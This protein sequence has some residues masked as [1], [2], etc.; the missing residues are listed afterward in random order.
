MLT[1][2][3]NYGVLHS[4][5]Q[6]WL[7][8]SSPL[9]I[10]ALCE[11]GIPI[12][13]AAQQH[14]GTAPGNYLP[15][16]QPSVHF[17]SIG[18]VSAAVPK[19]RVFLDY[20]RQVI[21][22]LKAVW[23]SQFCYVYVP[24]HVG[25]LAVLSCTLLCRSYAVYLRG[26]FLVG[27]PRMFRGLQ[28]SL[29]A[30]ARF[31]IC[32]GNQLRD[33]VAR[34]NPNAEAVVPM[35]P[36]LFVDAEDRLASTQRRDTV[37]IL[38]V[39]EMLREKGIF[40]LLSA[41][42]QLARRGQPKIRLTM[43]GEG[44]DRSQLMNE[45]RTRGL[46]DCVQCPGLIQDPRALAATYQT[47]DL[48]CLPS[49]SEGFPRVLY[50]AMRFALPV[51]T[52]PVGEITTVIEDGANGLLCIPGSVESLAEKLAML[53]ASE[54]LR[55]QL[56]AAGRATLEPL[57]EQWRGKTHGQQVLEWLRRSGFTG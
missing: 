23:S 18:V 10:D 40:E 29:L 34:V 30:K 51:L 16:R 38:Y 41:F 50:E 3:P 22:I 4:E 31:V 53:L 45:I 1:L 44:Q 35:S 57:L 13:V 54:S 19:W 46:A 33:R 27:T 48:F 12:T 43:I 25:L 39:G 15:C 8:A 9:F 49:Y 26:D 6:L 11:A 42:E 56:G 17:R 32:T 55:Q 36:V 28:R 37:A 24:G 52:T 21:P 2:F 7:E 5:Q 14:V 20:L 47:C